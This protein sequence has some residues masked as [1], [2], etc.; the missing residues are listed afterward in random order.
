M[1]VLNSATALNQLFV[2]H[3]RISPKTM[4]SEGSFHFFF[5][6][7][8]RMYEFPAAIAFKTSFSWTSLQHPCE[9]LAKSDGSSAKLNRKQSTQ[10]SH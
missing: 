8:S 7:V 6:W 2:L 10:G 4:L 5:I 3:T 9:H 1:I